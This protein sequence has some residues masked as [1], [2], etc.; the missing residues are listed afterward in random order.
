MISYK[1]IYIK[2]SPKIRYIFL[3]KVYFKVSWILNIYW[4]IM[5]V[6]LWYVSPSTWNWSSLLCE[7]YFAY[8]FSFPLLIYLWNDHNPFPSVM[9]CTM[10]SF[11]LFIWGFC[12]PQ[13]SILWLK[14]FYSADS[15]AN[16][17]CIS[18]FPNKQSI[19]LNLLHGEVLCHA[20]H[21]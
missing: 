17:I 15:M 21:C 10:V 20:M 4:H 3:T 1:H 13:P 8:L 11:M 7:N 18:V 6:G 19:S 12:S 2:F 14:P 5:L 16:W 9:F